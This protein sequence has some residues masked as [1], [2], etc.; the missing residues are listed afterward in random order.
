MKTECEK[1]FL[2]DNWFNY[3]MTLFALSLTAAMN[4][5]FALMLQY[6][7]EAVELSSD[8][9]LNAGLTVVGIYLVV[10]TLF[11]VLYRNYKNRYFNQALSQ[12]KD[13]IFAKMLG[14]SISQFGNETSSRFISA[15]SNDLGSIETHYLSGTLELFVTILTFIAAAIMMLALNWILALPVLAVALV[16]IWLSMRYGKKLVGKEAKTSDENMDFVAQV[17]DLLSGFTVIKSFKAEKEVLALFQKKN[18]SLESAKQD[19]R[20]TA[21]TVTIYASISSIIVNVLIFALG[22]FFAFNGW[23]TIGKVIAFIQLGRSILAP[24]SE[25]SPLVSNRRAAKALIG[26]ISQAIEGAGPQESPRVPFAGL[27]DGIVLEGVS[28]AYEG[29]KDALH[30]VSAVFEKGKSYAVV[31]GSGSGKSTLLK[32]LLGYSPNY[33]GSLKIDS[34][35]M[36]AIDLD[37]LYDHISVIQQ[38]VFLFDSSIEN[39][40]TMFRRFDPDRLHSAARR[41]GLSALILEKG[42]GYSCGEGGRNLSGGEKQRISIARCLIRETPILLMDEATAALDNETALNVESAI[43]EIENMT[44]IMVTHRFSDRV[45]RKYD[46]IIVMH[47]GGIIERGGFDGLMKA[48][49]YFYSL[50]TVSQA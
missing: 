45:M 49:G 31:G 24:V 40:I 34:I 7:I 14:K 30:G 16:C 9:I 47:K 46:E 44:R 23:M 22:F 11:S 10:Y 20:E 50:Y 25:L 28:F 8:G 29:D 21:D 32:L 36:R 39:N 41:A 15:F 1:Q 35:E 26:R 6:F 12:F 17:K 42:E 43:L 18:V 38:D 37:D 2:R 33:R 13:Y 5:L 19:R 3:G 27:E 48:G 4:V